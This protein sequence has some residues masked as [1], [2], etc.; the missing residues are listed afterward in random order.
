MRRLFE[1]LAWR[2]AWLLALAAFAGLPR[3]AAAGMMTFTTY[4]DG[5][6]ES[7]TGNG[8]FSVL[9]SGAGINDL[10]VRQFSG[11]VIDVSLMKFDLS[12]LPKNATITGASFVFGSVVTTSNVGRIVD[13]EGYSTTGTVG[14]ADATASATLLGQYDNVALGLGPQSVS[15][16]AS[17]LQSLLGSGAVGLRL[18]GDVETVNTAIA[19]LEG[20]ALFGDPPPQLVI[21]FSAVPEPSALALMTAG[22]VG[23]VGYVRRRRA[24][25]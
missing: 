18:Q 8:S 20:A 24:R 4:S 25:D 10:V 7:P 2:A 9:N 23:V 1:R 5:W 12:A 15:L 17:T 11:L 14:L 3:D 13:I 22:L 16:S 6:A 19:S 21:T